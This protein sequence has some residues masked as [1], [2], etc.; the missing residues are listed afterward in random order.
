MFSKHMPDV[1]A[2]VVTEIAGAPFVNRLA[3]A[4]AKKRAA[5]GEA[6]GTGGATSSAVDVNDL[7]TPEAKKKQRRAT[8]KAKTRA[9]AAATSA[10]EAQQEA[11][12]LQDDVAMV[13]SVDDGEQDTDV[14][15]RK[16]WW[17][18]DVFA[19][20]VHAAGGMPELLNPALADVVAMCLFYALE[21]AFFKKVKI[22]FQVRAALQDVIRKAVQKLKAA[23]PAG[24]T[25]D[26]V[27]F[28]TSELGQA[29]AATKKTSPGSKSV[30]LWLTA[31]S[32]EAVKRWAKINNDTNVVHQPAY[33]AS[34]QM[35]AKRLQLDR[36]PE[37]KVAYSISLSDCLW[38]FAEAI[39][40]HVPAA[41]P[42][43]AVAV[44][45]KIGSEVNPGCGDM[46]D[47]LP[48]FC[49][50][51]CFDKHDSYTTDVSPAAMF[52]SG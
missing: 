5:S 52:S 4:A 3:A 28:L 40:E 1:F 6:D 2:R 43:L 34:M 31:E 9:A 36:S 25:E 42:S 21:L 46:K 44:V 39:Y 20:M 47:V 29:D 22:N 17:I 32:A 14:P 12:T 38:T 49:H 16:R 10:M 45:A 23:V 18:D 15:S 13:M 35:V 19:C 48:Q 8:A 7:L 41:V 51:L 33:A 50:F 11:G 24:Q 37:E 30:N 27:A 26:I